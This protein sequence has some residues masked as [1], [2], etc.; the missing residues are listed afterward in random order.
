[1]ADGVRQEFAELEG[2]RRKRRSSISRQKCERTGLR[3][4]MGWP[5]REPPPVW[6]AVALA[7]EAFSSVPLCLRGES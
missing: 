5:V 4:P 6:P 3:I 1:M 7:E 2:N